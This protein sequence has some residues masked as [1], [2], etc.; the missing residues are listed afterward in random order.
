MHESIIL[1]LP[2]PTCIAHNSAILLR[3]VVRARGG[4]R[5]TRGQASHKLAFT[6]YSFVYAGIVH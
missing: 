2:S 6:R 4:L 1:V 3:S 5:K